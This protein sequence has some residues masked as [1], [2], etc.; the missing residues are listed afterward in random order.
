MFT[1]I[2]GVGWGGINKFIVRNALEINRKSATENVKYK[3]LC[4]IKEL[5]IRFINNLKPTKPI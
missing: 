2:K 1:D 5:K 3:S 4:F